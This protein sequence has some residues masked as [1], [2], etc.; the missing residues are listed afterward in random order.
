MKYFLSFVINLVNNRDNFVQMIVV[1]SEIACVACGFRVYMSIFLVL[2][3]YRSEPQGQSMPQSTP[4]ETVN[5]LKYV[6]DVCFLS[7]H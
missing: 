2:Q 7:N 6:F 5:D 3:I 1:T 4:N